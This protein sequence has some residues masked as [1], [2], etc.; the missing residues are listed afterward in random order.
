MRKLPGILTTLE[1]YER[2]LIHY[3]EQLILK[4]RQ[5]VER[6]YH[7]RQAQLRALEAAVADVRDAWAKHQAFKAEMDSK[8]EELKNAELQKLVKLGALNGL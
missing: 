3:E 8:A 1:D 4:A 7:P 6:H 2:N 5:P